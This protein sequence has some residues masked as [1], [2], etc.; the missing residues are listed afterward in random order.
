M[1]DGLQPLQLQQDP[2]EV[3]LAKDSFMCTSLGASVCFESMIGFG[4]VLFGFVSRFF[5]IFQCVSVS[6]AVESW[7]VFFFFTQNG[8][9]IIITS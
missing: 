1:H 5:F 2:V 7:T 9:R 4:A 8:C 6:L 3:G